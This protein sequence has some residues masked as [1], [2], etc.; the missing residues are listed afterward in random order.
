[1]NSAT[2]LSAWEQSLELT[3]RV[4]RSGRPIAAE[5]PLAFDPAFGAEHMV[6]ERDGVVVSS[7]VVLPRT[8]VVGEQK[9]QVGLI[10]SVVTDE[11]YRG[12]GFATELLSRAELRLKQ[13][14][15][16]LA[17]LWADEREFYAE[18]GY[19]P[20]GTELDYSVPKALA[21]YLPSTDRVR[22]ACPADWPALHE[23]YN[24]HSERV[25]RSLE[26]TGAL[27]AGPDVH[28][29]V[30]EGP[31]GIDGYAIEGRGE[32]LGGVVH[33]WGGRAESIL[34]CLGAHLDRLPEDQESLWWM[35]PPS[36]VELQQLM[37]EAG[38]E[39][40]LGVLG[41]GKLLDPEGLARWMQAVTPDS[42]DVQPERDG[43]RVAGPDGNIFLDALHSL[44][45]I[46][47]PQANRTL[48]EVVESTV[49]AELP[50][51]PQHAFL[52]GLDSI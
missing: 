23:L 2:S 38:V 25:E 41:M 15:A 13:S 49:G 19:V 32:D 31:E 34:T 52:W 42:V 26:E 4:M 17:L 37:N 18:R 22:M 7:V 6:I 5:Q 30:H 36:Q 21:E 8:L 16:V 45:A 44:F 47:P 9:V 14:G 28:A 10:G 3:M 43:V 48:V 39:G 11:A 35:V 33:E 46:V 29:L 50:Q 40:V 24:G 27:L 1:M 20:I 12:Q 51:L